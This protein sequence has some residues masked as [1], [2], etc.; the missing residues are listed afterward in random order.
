MVNFVSHLTRCSDSPGNRLV[1]SRHQDSASPARFMPGR[2]HS[3]NRKFTDGNEQ[4][5]LAGRYRVRRHFR[6]R[7]DCLHGPS[8]GGG[9]TTGSA[10]GGTITYGTTDK[11]VTLDPAGSYDAG[12]FMV[13]NQIYPFLMNSKPGSADASPTSPNLR[14]SPP[15]RNTPSSSSRASSSPTATR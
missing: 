6:F 13:M 9:T 5:G 10:G 11:V 1:Q 14:P 15:R 12:S 7:I 3:S 4:K 8:G 2:A